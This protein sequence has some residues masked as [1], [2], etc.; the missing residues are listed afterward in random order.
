MYFK[1]APCD[2]QWIM[3]FTLRG[4]RVRVS[5]TWGRHLEWRRFTWK[6]SH[7]PKDDLKLGYDA[8]ESPL[9]GHPLSS[10]FFLTQPISGPP[11]LLPVLE[12]LQHHSLFL[13]LHSLFLACRPANAG[14]AYPYQF[15]PQNSHFLTFSFFILV[16]SLE[17]SLDGTHP[18]F[19]CSTVSSSEAGYIS[20]LL[21]EPDFKL[22]DI[23]IGSKLQQCLS[24]QQTLSWV[25]RS[26][27]Q[28][29]AR[30]KTCSPHR[31]S[32]RI[33]LRKNSVYRM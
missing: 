28:P 29:G 33:G 3:L 14:W 23:T 9:L 11:Q 8:L 25:T 6:T 10:L 2:L 15:C 32:R 18:S 24:R 5:T 31:K 1:R 26:S 7:I 17:I 19:D 30:A 22:G 12:G 13:A 27:K 21:V 20:K 4:L 16:H